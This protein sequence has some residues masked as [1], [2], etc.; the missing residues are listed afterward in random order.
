MTDVKHLLSDVLEAVHEKKAFDVKVLDITGLSSIADYFVICSANNERQ[1]QSVAD[2]IEKEVKDK[3]IDIN[4][5]GYR[6]G[7]WI[8]MDLGDIIVHIFHKEDRDFYNLDR[9]WVDAV[10]LDVD[11]MI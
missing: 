2:E 8:L 7:R 3:N 5:E 6:N 10:N 1:V 4:L 9:L 11:N